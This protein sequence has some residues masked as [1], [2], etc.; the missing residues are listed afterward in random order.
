MNARFAISLL[1]LSS[2][3]LMP[4]V[5]GQYQPPSP[6]FC[7]TCS[8]AYGYVTDGRTGLSIGGATVEAGPFGVTTTNASG[9][10]NLD[11]AAGRYTF[12]ASAVGYV[13]ADQT[14]IV[15]VGGST[16]ADISLQPCA[17]NKLYLNCTPPSPDLTSYLIPAAIVI[18]GAFVTLGLSRRPKKAANPL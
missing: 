14:V 16:R 1:I 5:S 18:A 3:P 9:F 12:Q 2:M 6:N 7:S 4:S 11:V 8:G 10:Y 13:T 17:T 15:Q